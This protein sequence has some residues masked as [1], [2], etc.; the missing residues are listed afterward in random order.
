MVTALQPVRGQAVA[1]SGRAALFVFGQADQ[2]LLATRFDNLGKVSLSHLS[3]RDL[4]RL[5]RIA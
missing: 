1:R 4:R 3:E 2:I 5:D